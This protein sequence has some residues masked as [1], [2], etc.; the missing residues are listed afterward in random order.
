MYIHSTGR[1]NNRKIPFP[2]QQLQTLMYSRHQTRR[3]SQCSKISQ[4]LP[5]P[6]DIYHV[7][8]TSMNCP[9]SNS[10]SSHSRTL[11]PV[12]DTS[13]PNPGTFPS[14]RPSNLPF[15]LRPVF[16]TEKSISPL[17]SWR[18]ISPI[19]PVHVKGT[20]L[21]LAMGTQSSRNTAST[22]PP[23][24]ISPCIR[25]GSKT[26]RKIRRDSEEE[27]ELITGQVRL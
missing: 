25:S 12:H 20:L 4:N 17:L 26:E 9:Q 19:R 11:V 24:S 16:A 5:C 21:D 23:R 2:N 3:Q 18:T 7:P 13:L 27:G 1:S 6:F 8:S 15:T 14:N 10:P 22:I